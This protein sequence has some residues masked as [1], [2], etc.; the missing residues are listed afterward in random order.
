M[1]VRRETRSE[2][3]RFIERLQGLSSDERKRVLAE[4]KA[5]LAG[6]RDSDAKPPMGKERAYLMAQKRVVA[7]QRQ[8]VAAKT[9][10]GSGKKRVKVISTSTDEDE[11][12][13]PDYGNVN[14]EDKP[15]APNKSNRRVKTAKKPSPVSAKA[16]VRRPSV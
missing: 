11:D 8:A 10:A 6:D 15:P 13:S 5:F 16:P 3:Q 9:V 1:S 7:Q 2:H 4:Q 14:G 12:I